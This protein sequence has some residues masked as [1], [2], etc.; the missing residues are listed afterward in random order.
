MARAQLPARANNSGLRGQLA[1]AL[2]DLAEGDR[3]NRLMT[4]FK[5]L[6]IPIDL[7]EARTIDPYN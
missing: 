7:L 4:Y 3:I 6:A 2:I 5:T 1:E